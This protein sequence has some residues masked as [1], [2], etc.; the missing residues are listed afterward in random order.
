[1]T[2]RLPTARVAGTSVRYRVG[3]QTAF[4]AGD[5]M[6]PFRF[7]MDHGFEAFEWFSDR[8]GDHGIAWDSL[9]A[10]T[11]RWIREEANQRGMT[12]AVHAPWQATPLDERGRAALKES[13]AF[14]ADVGATVVVVH[15]DLRQGPEGFAR[16]LRECAEYARERGVRLAAENTVHTSPDDCNRCMAAV[17]ALGFG[18][19]T[20][21]MCL[22]IGHANVCEATRYDYVRFVN[23]IDPQ[24]RILHCHFHENWGDGDHHLLLFTGPAADNPTGVRLVLERLTERGFDGVITLEVWPNPPEKLLEA[25]TRL[26]ALAREAIHAREPAPVSRQGA[27]PAPTATPSAPLSSSAPQSAAAERSVEDVVPT[28]R[29]PAGAAPEFVR[30]SSRNPEVDA[31]VGRLVSAS[32]ERTSWRRRLETVRDLLQEPGTREDAARLGLLGTYLQF[33]GTG[34]LPC[35]EDG[36]HY[37]PSHHAALALTIERALLDAEPGAARPARLLSR[38]ILRWLPSHDAPFRRSEPLTRIRDIAHRNDIPR[39]LK[40]EI[41][42]TL[43]NK[44]HRSAG[45]EDLVTARRILERVTASGAEFSSAFVSEFRVFIGEL[46]EFFNASAL[47]A[48]LAA[49]TPELDAA[50][51]AQAE[52]LSALLAKA[53]DAVTE[54]ELER[55]LELSVSLRQSFASAFDAAFAA[56]EQR[57]RVVELK[58]EERA[59]VAL[60]ELANRLERQAQPAWTR[61]A[62][63]LQ[64]G[65]QHLALSGVFAARASALTAGLER[66]LAGLTQAGRVAE[67][68]RDELLELASVFDAAKRLA[69]R[70]MDPVIEACSLAVSALGPELGVEQRRLDV[71][72]EGEIRGGLAYPVSRLAQ[73]GA[74]RVAEALGT[75]PWEAIVPGVAEGTL[76]MLDRLGA[77]PE[78]AGPFILVLKRVEGDENL[79]ENVAGVLLRHDLPILSHLGIRARQAHVVLAAERRMTRLEQHKPGDWVRLSV[80]PDRVSL[81]AAPRTTESTRGEAATETV[82]ALST[83]DAT[84]WRV[85]PLESITVERG[86]PKAATARKLAELTEKLG[87]AAP[88]GWVIPFGSFELCVRKSPDTLTRLGSGIAAL[89]DARPSELGAYAEA[90]RNATLDLDFPASFVSELEQALPKDGVFVVRSSGNLEDLAGFSA[91]GL[92]E[93]VV[94]VSRGEVPAAIRRVWAS[95]HSERAV[96][97]RRAARVPTADVRMAVLIQPI[98]PAEYSFVLFTASPLAKQSSRAY[99]EIAAGL[100]EILCSASGDG[101]PFRAELDKRTGQAQV[102]SFA[103]YGEA[104]RPLPTEPEQDALAARARDAVGG[105][106]RWVPVQF[107][108]ERLVRDAAWRTRLLTRL[109]ALASG[110]ERELGVPQDVEGA[111]VGE[112]VYLVQA[113]PAAV[114]AH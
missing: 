27:E 25:R 18:A 42:H 47:E 30:P 39:D 24:V 92:Y 12:L 32:R 9:S 74:D 31:F 109:T 95:L 57:M 7:A 84:E 51:R 37:R 43:Q 106:A 54:A 19:D 41:K 40:E 59:F 21:G 96:L 38:R 34:A 1:M 62:R 93:S 112:S 108:E 110:L 3:N 20:V 44:L 48:D 29:S 36:G 17:R 70:E 53:G 14:A 78:G 103:S 55:Q 83:E 33:I 104:L 85:V 73:W 61:C 105:R 5:P 58:L 65:L 16:G 76:L 52:E 80:S 90:L 66:T 11:R 75:S 81:E 63:S 88:R 22:D 10:E 56:R 111:V 97:A 113:R 28:D 79:P 102:L 99:V 49:L 89:E 71:F 8:K 26:E 69:A 114:P 35:S 100:G 101:T 23:S 86:G 82:R 13:V 64:L 2:A 77:L 50:E 98:V 68:S 46:E 60:S 107:A 87:V 6:A 72:A 67:P 15:F 94:G 4:S 45:P 91:A